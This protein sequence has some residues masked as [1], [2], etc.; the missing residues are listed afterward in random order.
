MLMAGLEPMAVLC[1][2]MN[3]DGTMAR[4]NEVST[5]GLKHN[6]TVL[7]IEDIIT[8]RKLNSNYR[9]TVYESDKH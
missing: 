3:E 9:K 6:L 2:L 8:Y 7:S 4:L 1:E 5:F